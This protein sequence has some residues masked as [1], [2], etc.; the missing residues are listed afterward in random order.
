[1]EKTGFTVAVKY[2][3]R[4]VQLCGFYET[5]K[6]AKSNRDSLLTGWRESVLAARKPTSIRVR[7]VSEQEWANNNG[8]KL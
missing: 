8:I 2:H 7:E 3:K 5:R 6:I 1:M 4:P